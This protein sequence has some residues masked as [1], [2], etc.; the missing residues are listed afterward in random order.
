MVVGTVIAI[1]LA[2]KPKSI[3]SFVILIPIIFALSPGSHGLRQLETWVSGEQITG[4]NDL[5][6]LTF[7][8]LAIAMGLVV[9]RVIAWRW[10][11]MKN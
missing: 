5:T 7:T 10:R 8:L 9:G 1:I 4:I 3:P 11:W 6:T 2:R